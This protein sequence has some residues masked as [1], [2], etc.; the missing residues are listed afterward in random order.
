MKEH[1]KIFQMLLVPLEGAYP[2]HPV[3]LG[4]SPLL[5]VL[6]SV[7]NSYQRS[8]N[9]KGKKNRRRFKEKESE[10]VQKVQVHRKLTSADV[11]CI[12]T[13]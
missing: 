2:Q 7:V 10:E 9:K 1:K 13:R 6:S 8:K 12:P 3:F 11:G 5:F 4:S